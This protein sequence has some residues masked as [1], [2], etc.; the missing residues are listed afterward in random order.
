[1]ENPA[2]EY[3][4]PCSFSSQISTKSGTTSKEEKPSAEPT[5]EQKR[6]AHNAYDLLYKWRTPPGTKPDGSFDGSLLT[7]WLEQVERSCDASGH[8][9]IALDQTG[10][11]LAHSPADPSGLWIHKAAAEVL[12]D[13]KHDVMCS[14]FRTE[15]FNQRGVFTWTAGEDEKRLAKEY[16]E[17]A[18]AVDSEGYFRLAACLRELA[19]SYEHDADREASRDPFDR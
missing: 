17:K 5:E 18:A 15:L 1:L 7:N 13:E 10:K 14:A 2:S 11:V 19:T 3:S 12:N 9:R 16:R 6:I 8:L 4:S